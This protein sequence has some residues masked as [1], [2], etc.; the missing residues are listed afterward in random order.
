MSIEKGNTK[1]LWGKS[2]YH[3]ATG[4]NIPQ[5]FSHIFQLLVS[6]FLQLFVGLVHLRLHTP[7]ALGP[8]SIDDAV[9]LFTGQRGR[10]GGVNGGGGR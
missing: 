4:E 3:N 1:D 10:Q 8:F 6:L 5:R 9:L 2:Q 7:Q